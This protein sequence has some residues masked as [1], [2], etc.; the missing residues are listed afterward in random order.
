MFSG[1]TGYNASIRDTV[2]TPNMIGFLQAVSESLT[3]I[4]AMNTVM[5]HSQYFAHLLELLEVDCMYDQACY[6]N[7]SQ[8]LW[9]S[10]DEFGNVANQLGAFQTIPV[11]ISGIFKMYVDAG[12]IDVTTESG[13]VESG[14]VTLT[15]TTKNFPCG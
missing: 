6:T 15:W 1:W 5:K 7:V 10:P 8:I 2:S 3:E 11:F 14:P 13:I 4:P 9:A 12:L